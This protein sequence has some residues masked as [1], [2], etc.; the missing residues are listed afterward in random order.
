MVIGALADGLSTLGPAYTQTETA[1][2]VLVIGAGVVGVTTAYYLAEAGHR[3]TVI[4]RGGEVASQTSF[5]NGGQLSYGFAEALATPA[6]VRKIPALMAGR[7]FATRIRLTPKLVP[8]GLRFLLQCTTARAQANTIALLALARRS[9]ELMAGLRQL[10]DLDDAWRPAGKLVLLSTDEELAAAEAGTEAKR[11]HGFDVTLLSRAEAERVEPAIRT[12]NGPVRAAAYS[13]HDD[14]A[15]ARRF[16]I[17]LKAHLE[18]DRDVAFHMGTSARSLLRRDGGLYG[19]RVGD[20]PDDIV[21]GDAVVACLGAWSDELL[22]PLGVRTRIYPVRGYSVTL[23]AGPAAPT[24]S[25]TSLTNRFVFSRLNGGMR[26]AGFTDFDGFNTARDGA[27]LDT[28]VAAARRLAPQFADYEAA[29]E[30]RWGGFRPMTPSGLPVY[31]RT[32]VAGLYVNTGHGMLGWTLAA[33][34]A[35][36]VADAVGENV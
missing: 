13:R 26:I 8:W 12:F 33:A 3:V 4:E 11:A 14:V 15:D 28:L 27:R 20:A 31:G 21:T 18:C 10:V 24:A 23:P 34:T 35:K 22:R 1:M 17:A 25:L 36:S 6:F 16:T 19:I 29:D 2:H 9:S 32:R 5:A 7:N 30:H